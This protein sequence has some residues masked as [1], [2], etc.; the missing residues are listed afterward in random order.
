MVAVI[1]ATQ[2]PALSVSPVFAAVIS[3]CVFALVFGRR[4]FRRTGQRSYQCGPGMVIVFG[5]L[6]LVQG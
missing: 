4:V 5:V 3:V 1:A 6:L 2:A